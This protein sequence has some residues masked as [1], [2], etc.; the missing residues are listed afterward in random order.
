ME[1]FFMG[2]G[3][4]KIREVEFSQARNVLFN[5][6]VDLS[7]NVFYRRIHFVFTDHKT[8]QILNSS[9][10]HFDRSCGSR[11]MMGDVVVVAEEHICA[12]IDLKEIEDLSVVLEVGVK[13][14]GVLGGKDNGFPNGNGF[15]IISAG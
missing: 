6:S 15:K 8:S 13:V 5:L 10:V 9:G 1:A 3:E 2:R 14:I 4:M 11:K 7:D 12:A